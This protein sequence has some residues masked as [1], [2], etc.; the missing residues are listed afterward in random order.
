MQSLRGALAG[1]LVGVATALVV[2]AVSILP[3]LNPVWVGFDQGRAGA[4]A[5][6]G[7]DP[8]D[9]RTATDAILAD[10][11]IGP[12]AFDVEIAG[13][14]VLTEA[15]RDHMRDVRR[16]FAGFYLV[17]AVGALVLVLAFAVSRGRGRAALWRRISRAG[18]VVA[19]VTVVGGLAGLVF[20]DQAFLLF[21][22]VFFPQ[23]NF[24]FDPRTDHLVQL[25]PEPFW[26]ETSTGV[27]V[28]IVV[29]GVVM[30]WLGGR[31]ASAIEA[32]EAGTPGTLSAVPVR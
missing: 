23:G 12:P 29:L 28:V 30:A 20:F 8:A 5:L 10:L 9:L 16:V 2:V 24:L 4:A 17:A 32:R 22:E 14:P 1:L 26:V 6:T 31:R 13:V 3:F 21:H 18:A 19:G 7:F 15:E 27:G 25:F 11:V